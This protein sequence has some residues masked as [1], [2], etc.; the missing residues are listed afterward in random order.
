[1]NL[2]TLEIT[3]DLLSNNFDHY[4]EQSY[5][6]FSGVSIGNDGSLEQN[7]SKGID[8]SQLQL[9]THQPLKHL[10]ITYHTK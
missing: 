2:K 9:P 8:Y 7:F 3:T 10:K 1:M 6:E 5:S 4:N